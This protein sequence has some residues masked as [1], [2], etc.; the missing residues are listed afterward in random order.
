MN[1]LVS[2]V[3]PSWFEKKQDGKYGQDETFRIAEICLNRLLEV[4]DRDK[5]ELIIIDNGSTLAEELLEVN[6]YFNKADVLMVNRKNEGFGPAVN[7]GMAAATGN[8]I[9][10][11][12][13][14]ILVFPGWLEA[15][16]EVYEH[17][18][19]P[20]PVGLVM[21][22]V[23]KKEYQK[24]CLDEVGKLDFYKV[25][26]LKVEDLVLPH[27]EAI[28]PHAQFGS[29][30]CI[31]K[32]LYDKLR[33]EDGFFFDPQFII[34]MG[35]DRDLYQRLYHRGFDTYRTNKTRVMHVGNATI[36]K[37]K[38]HKTYTV[39]NREKFEKKW[40]NNKL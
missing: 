27:E 36:G 10:Q 22:N 7:Q 26:E 18:E 14:D 24:D 8:Y 21:P 20:L 1:K 11:M 33:K 9:I 31:K 28:E 15:I 4:T 39:S 23:I 32:E 17:S 2:I 35:E 34:G 16:L 37:V 3:I 13:N 40:E 5:F 29:T 19:L 30:W 12:N 6:D 25:L 38:D